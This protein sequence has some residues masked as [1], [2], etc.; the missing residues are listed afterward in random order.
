MAFLL[1]FVLVVIFSDITFCSKYYAES[2]DRVRK[3]F[4]LL[5]NDERMLFVEGYQKLRLNGMLDILSQVHHLAPHM[6]TNHGSDFFYWHSYF[7]WDF[8]TQIR[9]LGDK[10]KCFSLPY[11]DFT[12]DAGIE[13]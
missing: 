4:H 9:N 1:I 2:C 11:W 10:F 13:A 8:E 7:I 6:G 5:T 12:F 3:P